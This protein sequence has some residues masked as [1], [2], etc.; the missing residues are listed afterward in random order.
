MVKHGNEGNMSN[1]TEMLIE[2]QAKKAATAAE[3]LYE[4][5]KD[6]AFTNEQA[7]ELVKASFQGVA[8]ELISIV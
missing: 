1:P 6:K 8:K 7:F 3:I 4:A 2:K 5:L